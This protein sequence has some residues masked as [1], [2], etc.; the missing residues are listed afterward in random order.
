MSLELAI[1]LPALFGLLLAIVDFGGYYNDRL[2]LTSVA[3]NGAKARAAA[4]GVDAGQVAQ[5]VG[6]SNVSEPENI[7]IEQDALGANP[8]RR[9][10]VTLSYP[11]PNGTTSIFTQ[12]LGG[13]ANIE[14]K[15]LAMCDPDCA[16]C[17]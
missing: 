1:A 11:R 4:C 3:Y 7:V 13:L 17:S 15:G 2:L 6:E 16:A 5:L 8:F 9:Y 10:S 14:V 12:Q